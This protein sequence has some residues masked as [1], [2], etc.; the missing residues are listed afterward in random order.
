MSNLIY[1]ADGK[2]LGYDVSTGQAWLNSG[3]TKD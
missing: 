1:L 2:Q 3:Y